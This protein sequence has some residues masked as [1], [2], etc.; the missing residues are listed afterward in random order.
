MTETM[1][2]V[3][4]EPLPGQPLPIPVQLDPAD[5]TP[6]YGTAT[7]SHGLPKLLKF[8]AYRFPQ[9][10]ASRWLILLVA[11]QIAASGEI[12]REAITPGDQGE[13]IRHFSR[14]A[15]AHPLGFVAG[16]ALPAAVVGTAIWL[17][18]RPER[19][20]SVP[21]RIGKLVGANR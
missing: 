2:I 10:D 15:R 14:L 17:R 8:L 9:H 21:E 1:G 20:P 11:D 7:P 19:Q 5:L 3:Q 4:Q 6:V 18:G 12:T 16:L 13:V